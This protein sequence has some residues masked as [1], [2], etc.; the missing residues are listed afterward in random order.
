MRC[1]PHIVSSVTNICD[2]CYPHLTTAAGEAQKI[3]VTHPRD[4]KTCLADCIVPPFTTQHATPL[5]TQNC[6]PNTSQE[7]AARRYFQYPRTENH[8]Q[9]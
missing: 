1:F 7:C 9:W 6:D 5:T 2:R 4:V 8:H 3:Q